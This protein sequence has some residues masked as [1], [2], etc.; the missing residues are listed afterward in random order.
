MGSFGKIVFAPEGQASD[1]RAVQACVMPDAQSDL[2][3]EGLLG[4]ISH[5]AG[6]KAAAF[7]WITPPGSIIELTQHG[8]PTAFIE[9][10]SQ[11][12]DHDPLHVA[13]LIAARQPVAT[14]SEALSHSFALPPCYRIHLE[15]FDVGDELD[16]LIDDGGIPVA[17]LSLFRSSIASRFSADDLDWAAIRTD[18]QSALAPHWRMRAR[19]L[20]RGLLARSMTVR[21]IE[22]LS[23]LM[24]GASNRDIALILGISLTTA[25]THMTNIRNKLGADSRLGVAALVHDLQYRV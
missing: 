18:L 15:A 8:L 6:A 9:N 5:M 1:M 22:I 20:E 7:S 17:C 11:C 4:C 19:N 3:I 16:I 25:K 13:T 14:L 2:M 24:R 23:L 21:E 10:Y 12:V